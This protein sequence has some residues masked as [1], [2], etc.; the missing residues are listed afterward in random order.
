MA[1]LKPQLDYE[2][3]FQNEIFKIPGEKA[4]TATPNSN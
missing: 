2:K 4:Q 1:L 3:Y